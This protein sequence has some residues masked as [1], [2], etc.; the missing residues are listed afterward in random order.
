[1][2]S[3]SSDS[4]ISQ[5]FTTELLQ[6]VTF[7]LFL[8]FLL[9]FLSYIILSFFTLDIEPYTWMKWT[10]ITLFY[11][12]FCNL[13]YFH[14]SPYILVAPI[15]RFFHNSEDNIKN[16]SSQISKQTSSAY[17]SAKNKIGEMA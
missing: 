2:S 8:S 16:I 1:M 7:Y 11:F 12:T 14:Y 15:I 9:L 6:S 4:S 3:S 10:A 5:I 17:N 13:C